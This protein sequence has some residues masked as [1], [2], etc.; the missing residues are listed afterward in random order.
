MCAAGKGTRVS[1]SN[2]SASCAESVIAERLSVVPRTL[3]TRSLSVLFVS[4]VID[5]LCT[6]AQ[7]PRMSFGV[8]PA[9]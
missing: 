5:S 6:P 9:T 4:I 8:L 7:L 1:Y 2:R 3:V